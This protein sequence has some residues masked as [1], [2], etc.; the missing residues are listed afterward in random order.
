[1][2]RWQD[3]NRREFLGALGAAAA[4]YYVFPPGRVLAG[5]LP[6]APMKFAPFEFP[7]EFIF[8]AATA[9]YQIEGAW[10][11]DGK[12]E[13][14]W[15]HFVHYQ[16]KKIKNHE[17]G[18]VADDFYH[19]YESDL[20]LMKQMNIPAFRFSLSWPRII[21][22]GTGTINQRGI[23]FYHRVIDTCLEKNIEPWITCYHWDLPQTLEEKG[24]WTNRDVIHWFED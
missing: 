20:S 16:S 14:I 13:S 10:N 2:G 1:M 12:G 5:E 6:Q 8:G 24:G 17:T 11:E 7:P 4:S 18:D 23:D 9:A 15:D 19:R 22:A 21:P 3:L